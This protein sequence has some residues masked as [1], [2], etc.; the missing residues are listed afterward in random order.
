MAKDIGLES[1]YLV[2]DNG[3]RIY[4][5]AQKKVI[6][7]SSINKDEVSA[8]IHFAIMQNALVLLSASQ[9]E[10]GYS[11]NLLNA[12]SLDKKHYVPLPYTNNYHKLVKFINSTI[13]HSVL[14]FHSERSKMLECL[15]NFNA[16]SKD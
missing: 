11:V 5:I 6:V 3:A 14:V 8:I 16:L 9:K 2:S 15:S 10:Y 12:L 7:D 4:D 1:G 13:I